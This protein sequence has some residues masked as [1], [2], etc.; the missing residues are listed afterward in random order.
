MLQKMS[1]MKLSGG[2]R[3]ATFLTY[4]TDVESGGFTMHD[5]PS[6][7][8]RQ[9]KNVLM[10]CFL[11]SNRFPWTQHL[12]FAAERLSLIMDHGFKI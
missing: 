2:A 4:L 7:L 5:I 8:Q 6:N 11:R 3:L 1:K 10:K 12:S 9:T